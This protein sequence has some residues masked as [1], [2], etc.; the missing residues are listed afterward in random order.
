MLPPVLLSVYPSTLMDKHQR[1]LN[2]TRSTVVITT[3]LRPGQVGAMLWSSF[4][5]FSVS[6]GTCDGLGMAKCT[7]G[8]ASCTQSRIFGS[9]LSTLYVGS[10]TFLQEL[11]DTGLWGSGSRRGAQ[12]AD[13][14]HCLTHIFKGEHMRLGCQNGADMPILGDSNYLDGQGPCKNYIWGLGWWCL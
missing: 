3:S 9:V 7:V 10:T 14:F 13:C 1:A 6:S 11:L 4:L 8:V 5:K 2:V 12:Q